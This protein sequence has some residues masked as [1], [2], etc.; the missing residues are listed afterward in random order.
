MASVK[1][2]SIDWLGTS[3]FGREIWAQY[4]LAVSSKSSISTETPDKRGGDSATTTKSKLVFGANLIELMARE[5]KQRGNES[6][7]ALPNIVTQLFAQLPKAYEQ[8]GIFRLSPNRQVVEALVEQT[9]AGKTIE[10]DGVESNVCAGLLKLFFRELSE[11]LMTTKLYADW[12]RSQSIDNPLQKLAVTKAL[13]HKLPVEHLFVLY[14]LCELLVQF[15]KHSDKSNMNSSNLSI[16]FT[17]NL[18]RLLDLDMLRDIKDAPFLL[19]AM[20]SLLDNFSFFFDSQLRQD[21]LVGDCISEHR[22]FGIDEPQGIA[23]LACFG[24][25]F[26]AIAVELMIPSNSDILLLHTPSAYNSSR[27][28][29]HEQLGDLFAAVPADSDFE[30]GPT[31]EDEQLVEQIDGL[32]S[33]PTT[34]TRSR[35]R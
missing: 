24:Q 12:V 3:D 13:L 5:A 27:P 4:V 6:Q 1:A 32:L 7:L 14:K 30:C 25:F 10:L 22:I 19:G 11:P 23:D 20:K 31:T 17:P 29:H 16:V 34:T 35:R 26:D 21:R 18:F 15:D 9:N 33:P 28:A 2:T 8:V